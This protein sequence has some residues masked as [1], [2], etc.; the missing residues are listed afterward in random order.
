M[1]NVFEEKL[2]VKPENNPGLIR[3]MGAEY[4]KRVDAIEFAVENMMMG[5]DINGLKEA[6]VVILG[7]SR[8]SK[9][10]LSLYLANRN[11]KVMNVP[12]YKN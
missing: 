4:F 6:D 7:V 3:K 11:I 1:L 2:E 10:P 12:M 5:K 8:T 9:T